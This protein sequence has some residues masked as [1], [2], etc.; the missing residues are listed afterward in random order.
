MS[1]ANVGSRVVS[2]RGG[3]APPAPPDPILAVID[4]H[5]RLWSECCAAS[6]N[7]EEAD[8]LKTQT[9]FFKNQLAALAAEHNRLDKAE[10]RSL[11]ALSRIKP[12]TPAGAA[13]LIDY[14]I[15]DMK[16]GDA[17][18]HQDALANIARALT[19]MAVQS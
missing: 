3:V 17:G 4:D 11:A 5:R 6:A 16:D 2:M 14:I 12:T 13:A 8:R 7:W 19:K 9:P 18:W 15:E 10:G 1:H